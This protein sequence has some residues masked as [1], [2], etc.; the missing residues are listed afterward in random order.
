MFELL[1]EERT[2]MISAQNIKA[3][4]MNSERLKEA[5]FD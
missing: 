2:G 5:G 3:F 4:L 1:D